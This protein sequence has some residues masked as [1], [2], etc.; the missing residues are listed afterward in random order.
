ML[1]VRMIIRGKGKVCLVAVLP[2]LHLYK[3]IEGEA[4]ALS[5]CLPMRSAWFRSVGLC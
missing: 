5:L 1:W 2:V 3:L 4:Q